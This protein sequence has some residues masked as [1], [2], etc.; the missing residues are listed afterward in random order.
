[1]QKLAT[2]CGEWITGSRFLGTHPEFTSF[3]VLVGV[4]ILMDHYS[5]SP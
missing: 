4:D 3:A 5:F 1:M 2:A